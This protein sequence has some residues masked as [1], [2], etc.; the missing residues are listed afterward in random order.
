MCTE[1][2]GWNI[3]ENEIS[4]CSN[5]YNVFTTLVFARQYAGFTSVPRILS[6]MYAK[7]LANIVYKFNAYL[8]AS[9]EVMLGGNYVRRIQRDKFYFGHDR[10]YFAKRPSSQYFHRAAG[11][12]AVR[13]IGNALTLLPE[14]S[15]DAHAFFHSDR[16]PLLTMTRVKAPWATWRYMHCCSIFRTGRK[17]DGEY[18]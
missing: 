17:N 8:Q 14:N 2:T 16:W 9:S 5:G 6:H 10:H 4:L 15:I 1:C 12:K 11:R 3:L 18:K 13:Q 7:S